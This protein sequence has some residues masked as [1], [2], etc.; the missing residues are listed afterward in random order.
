[1]ARYPS[2]ND[3]LD[4]R[5][6]GDVLSALFKR[7]GGRVRGTLVNPSGF[8]SSSST[9]LRNYSSRKEER[10][11]SVIVHDRTELGNRDD[12]TGWTDVIGLD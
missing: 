1:M 11:D 4:S 5:S 7:G 9:D 12:P 6:M 2:E 10:K 3:A 8:D